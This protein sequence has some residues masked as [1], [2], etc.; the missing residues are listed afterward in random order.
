MTWLAAG[1]LAAALMRLQKGPA[2]PPAAKRGRELVPTEPRA[3]RFRARKPIRLRNSLPDSMFSLYR[4]RSWGHHADAFV[5]RYS[6]LGRQR[7][8]RYADAECVLDS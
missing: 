4:R 3:P 8:F 5:C 1:E 7:L 6:R 2:G